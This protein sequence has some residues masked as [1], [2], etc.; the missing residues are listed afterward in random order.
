MSGVEIRQLQ[1]QQAA[2]E[3][4]LRQIGNLEKR[5][6]PKHESLWTTL[7]V[8][9]RQRDRVLLYAVQKDV[10]SKIMVVVGYVMFRIRSVGLG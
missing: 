4:V 5:E 2:H 8:E 9:L 1:Q 7:E 10:D 3:L 6:F